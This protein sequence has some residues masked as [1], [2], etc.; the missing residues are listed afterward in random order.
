MEH[1]VNQ[2]IKGLAME[3]ELEEEKGWLRKSKRREE[4]I[5]QSPSEDWKE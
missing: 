5:Q 3:H 2:N 1:D 4:M